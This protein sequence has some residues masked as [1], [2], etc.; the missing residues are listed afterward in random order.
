MNSLLLDKH[1]AQTTPFPVGLEVSHA[2]GSYIYTKDGKAYL[3]MISGLAVSNLGHGNQAVKKAI[4]EQLEKYAHVMVY[5][6]FEQEAQ[7]GLAEKLT[8][9]LPETLN[10]CYFVN[11]GTEAIEAAIKLCR[12]VTGR[13]KLMAFEG[14]Y[15][16]GTTGA[17]A[18]SYNEQ[19]KYAVRPLMPDVAFIELNNL[20]HLE[21]I[22]SEVAGVF[23]ETIQGDAGIRIPTLE[24]MK[25]LREKCTAMGAMLV[26]DEIQAGMGR[27]GTLWAFEQFGIVPDVLCLGKALGAGLPMGALVTQRSHMEKFT[28]DPMLGHITTFGG[29]PVICASALAGLN[30][31]SGLLDT[32]SPAEITG[33]QAKSDFLKDALGSHSKVKKIRIRGFFLAI[34]LET[35]EEVEKAFNY[36][37]AHG[38]ITFWFLSCKNA[39]RLAPPLNISMEDLKKGIAVIKDALDQA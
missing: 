36:C 2:S 13:S 10:N 6:E 25:A 32:S 31:L 29:N 11:S 8:S 18:I 34:E 23:L 3:D 24:F 26:L 9:L 27:T 12:R 14:A 35:A 7:S 15:H 4:T 21:R 28:F 22:T 33:L 20:T 37:L 5:G 16:G 30:E 19:K 17:L 1:L 38:V 39:F